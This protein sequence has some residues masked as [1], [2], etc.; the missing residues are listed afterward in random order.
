MSEKEE[1]VSKRTGVQ[2]VKFA[3]VGFVNTGV[4]WVIFF[5]LT[6]IPYF[7]SSEWLAKTLSFVLAATNSFLMNSYWTFKQEF[8]SGMEK[9]GGTE[10]KVG[11]GTV[12]YV[13]F[14]VVSVIGWALNTLIFSLMR[15]RL[16]TDVSERKSQLISLFFA[17]AVVVVWN[18]LANKF[19]TYK[20]K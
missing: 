4:D 20:E 19:W 2:F 9:D 15:Y 17:S 3:I 8:K 7:D 18:F 11:R 10:G 14:M 6:L 16:F 13:K 1:F 12:Y 5:L